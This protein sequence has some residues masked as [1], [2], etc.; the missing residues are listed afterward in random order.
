MMKRR[1]VNFSWED[2]DAQSVFAE[3]VPFPD[4]KSSAKDVDT[5]MP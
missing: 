2:E 5:I 1:I 3:W 4:A